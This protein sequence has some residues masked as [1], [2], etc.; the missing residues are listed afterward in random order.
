[1]CSKDIADRRPGSSVR[2]VA[3]GQRGFNLIELLISMSLATLVFMAVTIMYVR[4]GAVIQQQNDVLDMNR[5]ARFALE[6]L[7]RDLSS[8]GSNST[9]NSDYDPLVCPKPVVSLHAVTL[10]LKDGYAASPELNPGV[11]PAALTLFG[12]LDVKRRFRTAS[13]QDNKLFLYDDGANPLPKTQEEYDQIFTTDRFVR[14]SGADGAQMYFQVSSA[15]FGDA[16]ITLTTSVPHMGE[17]QVCG[18]AGFGQGYW[19][20]VQNFVRYRV[21]ADTRPGAALLVSGLAERA[22][23]VRER[24]Q[25]DGITVHSQTV[26]AENAVDFS[27]YDMVVDDDPLAEKLKIKRLSTVYN[28]VSEAGDG[29][30]GNTAAATPE[31]LRAISLKVSLRSEWPDKGLAH[32]PRQGLF[33]PINTYQLSDDGRG[34][35][36]VVSLGSRVYLP[37][38]VSRNL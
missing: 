11:R 4:Q 26:L 31:R 9:P 37:T 28:V 6:H 5:E 34:A 21:V 3:T 22:L 30:L 33:A 8:L 24:L 18:F 38:L 35:H 7:R 25:T 29:V 2:V 12:S 27:V 10:S 1:M 32:Q 36:R 16:S 20:D 19:V 14:V 17:G 15:G 13:I 23:L